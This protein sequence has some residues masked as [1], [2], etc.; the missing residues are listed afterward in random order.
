MP[1]VPP[2]FKKINQYRRYGFSTVFGVSYTTT[3]RYQE[4]WGGGETGM[5]RRRKG[6]SDVPATDCHVRRVAEHQY[7]SQTGKAKFQRY[8][9]P[10]RTLP[11]LDTQLPHMLCRSFDSC[12]SATRKQKRIYFIGPTRRDLIGESP[13]GR[14]ESACKRSVKNGPPAEPCSVTLE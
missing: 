14:F 5:L 3:D 2:S 7:C 11:I 4:L 9:I 13:V 1:N 10:E 6:T 12:T 8:P